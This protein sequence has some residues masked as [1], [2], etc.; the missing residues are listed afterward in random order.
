L[1]VDRAAPDNFS[2]ELG[3]VRDQ[4]R[5]PQNLAFIIRI[6]PPDV[7]ALLSR[8]QNAAPARKRREDR[9]RTVVVIRAQV[10]GAGLIVIFRR[11]APQPG[12]ILSIL[13]RPDNFAGIET[14]GDD[15]I[16]R[17]GGRLGVGIASTD[18]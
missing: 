5:T 15:G 11:A 14:E 4:R 12:V 17:V 10:L 7:A 9:R 3:G 13:S 16:G 2:A 18:I 6:V 8:D 1:L